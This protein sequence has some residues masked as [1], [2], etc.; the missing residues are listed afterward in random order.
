MQLRPLVLGDH[1][2][3][4][5]DAIEAGDGTYKPEVVATTIRI[6]W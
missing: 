5:A 2:R 1:E 3:A 6:G 4:R